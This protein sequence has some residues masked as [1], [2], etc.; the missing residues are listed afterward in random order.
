MFNQNVTSP[1]IT[2]AHVQTQEKPQPLSNAVQK[3]VANYLQQ[4]NGQ[5]V[6]DL[7]ELVLSELEKPLLEEVMKYT[8]GNQ[9]RAANL[10]GINRGT[11]RKKLK[12]YGMS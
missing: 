5:D 9:T 3:A 10:M 12:Q 1:F 8:R 4:L 11:L 2:N 7:Y 6:N